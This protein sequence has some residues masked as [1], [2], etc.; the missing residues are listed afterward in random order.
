[1]TNTPGVN[2]ILDTQHV[3][4][5]RYIDVIIEPSLKLSNFSLT[6]SVLQ[7]MFYDWLSL[8]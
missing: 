5:Q 2:G 3:L 8:G 7:N 4:R 6:L 1:M